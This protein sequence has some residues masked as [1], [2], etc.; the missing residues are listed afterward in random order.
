MQQYNSPP[1][2]FLEVRIL[3]DFKFSK[4]GSADSTGVTGRFC[5]S[6]D[7]KEFNTENADP[8][9]VGT[10]GLRPAERM[11]A[12]RE[13]PRG[14]RKKPQARSMAGQETLEGT[15][16]QS[17]G[18][19]EGIVEVWSEGSAWSEAFWCVRSATT[20]EELERGMARLSIA[21]HVS[22]L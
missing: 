13:L 5:A 9:E 3:K 12:D 21:S 16:S 20:G 15:G 7:S 17:E 6:A 10:A 8:A 11:K 19:S 1:P 22:N 14:K 18:S 4:F 2:I